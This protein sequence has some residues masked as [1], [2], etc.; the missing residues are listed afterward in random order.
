VNFLINLSGELPPSTKV[1]AFPRLD[2]L[3]EDEVRNL[4]KEMSINK[5]VTED[6][7]S[8]KWFKSTKASALLKD[9]WNNETLD[10]LR[11]NSFA[12]RLISLNKVFPSIPNTN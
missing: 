12:C 9:W 11:K 2:P 7:F 1:I 10:S 4:Q 6:G 5:A 3:N 8:D